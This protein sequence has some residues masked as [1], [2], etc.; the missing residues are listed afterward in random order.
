MY[1]LSGTFTQNTMKA[2]YVLEELEVDYEF[3]F[4][5]L[6]KGENKTADFSKLTPVGK[7]PVLQHND[8]SLFESGAICRYVANVENSPIYPTDKLQRAKVDQWMDFF[9]CHLGR[10]LN[11][12][13]FEKIIKTKAGLGATDEKSC[14]EA[15]KFAGLQFST[16]DKWLKDNKYFIGN[17]LTIADFFAFA[18]IEQVGAVGVSLTE[19]PHVE[20]W[21]NEIEGRNSIQRGREKVKR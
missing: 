17:D 18:Y 1:R 9:S 2:L 14:E 11:T 12:L 10:W 6:S 16:V 3:Q 19:Y 13:F 7:V 15:V 8:D 5:D 21:F 20:R 4:V